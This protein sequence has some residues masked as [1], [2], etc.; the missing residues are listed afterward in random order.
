LTILET[1]RLKLRTLTLSDIK[2]L[3]NLVFLD[4]EVVKYTFG[5]EF[6]T[7]L[8]VENFIKQNCNFDSN[9][10]LSIIEEKEKKQI[11]GLAGV[12]KCNY[13]GKKD[14]EFGFILGKNYWNKGF[15][16]EIGQAQIDFVKDTLKEKRVLALAHKK[17]T[18]SIKCLKK[19]GLEYIKTVSTKNRGDREVY[20]LDF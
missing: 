11:I 20:I 2:T 1:K 6:K 10:G 15:A 5:N 12:I 16:T 4:K 19:L 17:N 9:L 7:F 13:L 3:Y 18:S 8:E 14:Y